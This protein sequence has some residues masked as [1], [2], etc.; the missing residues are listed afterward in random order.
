MCFFGEK[1]QQIILVDENNVRRIILSDEKII[2]N[3]YFFLTHQGELNL[4]F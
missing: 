4:S 1:S 3:L 2:K